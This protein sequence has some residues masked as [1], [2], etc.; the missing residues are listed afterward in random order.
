M[1]IMT[2][3]LLGSG[4]VLMAH[5]ALADCKVSQNHQVDFGKYSS[6]QI[7]DGRL[8]SQ[9]FNSGFGCRGLVAVANWALIKYKV[10]NLPS[11]LTNSA[12]GD[13]LNI[14]FRDDNH[15]SISQGVEN[16]LSKFDFLTLFNG[17]DN[18]IPFYAT[19]NPGQNVSPGVYESK[20]PFNLRWYYSVPDIAIFG[21]GRFFESPG[22]E[23]GAGSNVRN[24]GA[25]EAATTNFKITIDPDCRISVQDVNLGTAVFANQLQPVYTDVGI[26][27]SSRT[28]YS[29]II[30]DGL[31][32]NGGQRR[33]RSTN[34]PNSYI[35][36]DI[37][38]NTINERW[39]SNGQQAWSSARATQNAGNY[40]GRTGQTFRMRTE[41]TKNNPD[42]L[43]AGQYT[44]KLIMQINF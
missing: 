41:V 15:A 32:P 38:K 44:D 9:V 43:P 33:L 31:S 3:I 34:N 12:N 26:R 36:Y 18:S 19:I 35:N 42:N 21:V 13:V 16:I 11:N 7:Y 10:N 27:C 24:W 37:Y 25:G 4:L 28:P 20:T 40:D 14:S 1:K 23:R 29:V 30:N 17:P 6:I 2:K 39:G 5:T 22:F 8:S